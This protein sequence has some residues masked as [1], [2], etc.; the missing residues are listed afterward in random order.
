MGGHRSRLPLAILGAVVAAG[1]A[2]LIL[3][4]RHGLIDPASVDTT[5]YFSPDQVERARDYNGPQRLIALGGMVL[6]AGTLAVLALRPPRRVRAGF[7]RL[8]RRPILGSAVAAAGISVV[9]VVVGLPLSAIA[10][11]RAVDVGLST[12]SWG[13]WL[14]DVAKSVGI[15]AVLAALGGAVVIALVRRLRNWWAPAA[16]VV[17]LF[18][19]AGTYLFPVVID[20]IF[21]KFERLP[22]GALRS[23]VLS[24]AKRAGVDVGQVYRV[25]ASRRT[26]GAN[27]YVNGLGHTKRVVLYDN[28][29]KEFPEDQVRSVVAHELG[30]VKHRDVPRGL[31]WLAIVAPA[32]T[33][34]VQQLTERM[35]RGARP[36]PAA[37]PAIALS[38]ALVSL[39][40]GSASNV[41]SRRV[42][43]SAD[44]FALDTTRDP[45][46]FIDL[47][48]RLAITNIADPDPPEA[49][50]LLFGTHPTSVER[51]G[52][53]EAWARGTA[54]SR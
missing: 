47:E 2:T 51:I 10:Q 21:N 41:L 49:W 7:E 37:L 15:E 45:A 43:A 9:L 24:I 38:V 39:V 30:H 18:A 5:A 29:I 25:D 31:L 27:A 23:D 44:A 3:R 40:L 26:T 35:R 22:D 8:S 1:V 53:G 42:E 14:S 20:P 11:Q 19:V 36:G 34:L 16:A 46:A 52:M 4:P 50:Q 17:V 32:G 54:A 12:Q 13:G 28:L 48:R 33:F 6:S